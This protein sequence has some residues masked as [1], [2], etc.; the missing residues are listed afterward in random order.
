MLISHL[1]TFVVWGYVIHLG[2]SGELNPW[3][4]ISF[5]WV[6]SLPAYRQVYSD[7]CGA[8]GVLLGSRRLKILALWLSPHFDG[9]PVY[10]PN[11][12]WA[13]AVRRAQEKQPNNNN[14]D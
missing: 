13:Q 6:M 5:S 14:D 9:E 11:G 12:V 10:G 8:A 7:W 2:V 1:I 4:T 3:V